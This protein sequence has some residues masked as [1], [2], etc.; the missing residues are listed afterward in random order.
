MASACAVW[1]IRL[2]RQVISG[3]DAHLHS[4]PTVV[5]ASRLILQQ[6]QAV[7]PMMLR[8]RLDRLGYR[9]VTALPARPG[10]YRWLEVDP[11]EE[12]GWGVIQLVSRS[13]DRLL[14]ARQVESTDAAGHTLLSLTVEDGTLTMITTPDQQAGPAVVMLGAEPLGVLAGPNRLSMRS[15]DLE[16]VPPI[17]LAA[18]LT[19]EDRRFWNHPGVDVRAIVRAFL[20]NIRAGRIVQGGSTVTQ[21][22]VKNLFLGHEKTYQRKVTEAIMAILLEVHYSKQTILEAYLNSIYFGA[23]RGVGGT[24]AQAVIGIGEAA[25]FY[26]G[27]S[28]YELS[29]A[30]QALLAAMIKSPVRYEPGHFQTDGHATSRRNLVLQQLEL[31]DVITP[32]MSEAARRTPVTAWRQ[33]E[34]MAGNA[35]YVVDWVQQ[36]LTEAAVTQ[37]RLTVTTPGA[38]IITTIDPHLQRVAESAIR[39]GLATLD[40]QRPET[41]TTGAATLQAALVALDPRT[42]A[43]KALVGGRDY[44]RSQFNRAVKALRQ[45]GSLFKPVVY[46]AALERQSNALPL[47]T[48]ASVVHDEP[49]TL[50]AGGQ[51]W[52]PKNVDLTYRGAVTF[53]QVAESSLN[54]AT[55]HI[56]AE[57]GF[58]R[59]V[60]L[61]QAVGASGGR[62]IP[63]LP[64]VALGAM[65]AT[66]LEMATLYATLANGGRRV[67]PHVIEWLIEAQGEGHTG[68]EVWPKPPPVEA[69]SP[70][71]AYLVTSLLSGVIDHGT[72]RRVRSLGFDRPA[73]GKTGTSSHLHDAWFAGYTPELVA[74]V[75]V[76]YDQPKPIG[77]T[78]SQAALPI[79]TQFMQQALDGEPLREFVRPEGIISRKIDPATG[80]LA[81]WRCPG[82]AE[83]WFIAGTEPR[84]SC[85]GQGTIDV[86]QGWLK[87]AWQRLRGN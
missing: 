27:R 6:G 65:E 33:P 36:Q 11:G 47:F 4:Q 40:R 46:L 9:Q 32:E 19:M 57:V 44:Q 71:V 39:R 28:V 14:S 13:G 70:E 60:A 8:D 2:D 10:D 63:P 55:V 81:T 66:P 50:Q 74:L 80:K 49:I 56:A 31:D 30:E 67:T 35:P 83:E 69:V 25:T 78:G 16:Q 7:E 21:Q 64:S 86:V 53:R 1:V 62:I 48:L 15:I 76:G 23:R 84:E 51:P 24:G 85:A 26:F 3:F 37:G 54:A 61:A 43:V 5:Y 41:D 82:G 45:P 34:V 12:R 17:L 68:V 18:I 58:D 29:I 79:W 20:V 38:E 75:W 77:L 22:L 59:V 73:A 42:G 72:G 52:S 87:R